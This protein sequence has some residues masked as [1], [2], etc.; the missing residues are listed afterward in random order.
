MHSFG[1]APT[2]TSDAGHWTNLNLTDLVPSGE[3]ESIRLAR[4]G[5]DGELNEVMSS[6]SWDYLLTDSLR[7][8]AIGPNQNSTNNIYAAYAFRPRFRIYRLDNVRWQSH[9]DWRVVNRPP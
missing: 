4:V 8:L 3:G 1:K 6:D 2:R 5:I 9:R 7:H